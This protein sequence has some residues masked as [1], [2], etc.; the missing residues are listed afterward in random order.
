MMKKNS[1]R[2]FSIFFVFLVIGSLTLYPTQ[3]NIIEQQLIELNIKN[4]MPIEILSAI[5]LIN[6]ILLGVIALLVGHF[7]S[8]K[9]GLRSIIYAKF[10]SNH[11]SVFTKKGLLTAVMFGFLSALAALMINLFLRPYLP[12]EYLHANRDFGFVDILTSIFY[13]GIVE[14]L[15]LRWGLMTFIVFILWRIFNRKKHTPSPLIFWIAIILVAIVFSIGH[16]GSLTM[17]VSLLLFFRIFI[18]NFIA[19]ILFGFIFWRHNIETTIIAHI[20][21]NISLLPLS[22]IASGI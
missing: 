17:D 11:L 12:E 15:T 2:A 13:G 22:L 20:T 8:K 21:A 14:E 9:V 6:P 4:T 16:L 18:V 10:D 5:S 1:W 7:L 3:K 19:G